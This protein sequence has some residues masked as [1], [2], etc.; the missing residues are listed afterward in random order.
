[1]K[2]VKNILLVFLITGINNILLAQEFQHHN[3]E[4]KE[5]GIYEVITSGIYAHSFMNNHGVKASELHFTYWFNHTW[6]GGFSYTTKYD[7]KVALH[8]V[9]LLGSM[10]LSRSFTLNIGP[11]F[12]LPHEDRDFKLGLYSETE[13]NI[14][15]TDFFHFGPVFGLT[16]SKNTEG[17]MGFH[18]GFEF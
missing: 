12:E 5:R 9:A 18:L 16:I 4:G 2:K 3:H 15:P 13:I 10:N 17:I 1:M 8:D 6:G 14:R 11:N 7:N